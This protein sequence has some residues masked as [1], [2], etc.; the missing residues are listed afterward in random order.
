MRY[1]EQ[2]ATIPQLENYTQE[3]YESRRERERNTIEP[4]QIMW[5]QKD[6]YLTHWKE[7]TKILSKLE[8][9]LAFNRVYTVAE[10]LTT[11]TDPN[12]RKYFTMYRLK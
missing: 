7:L 12:L 2:G 6:N 1:R 5:K 10:Y 11:V 8:C 3:E 9:Y 4:K